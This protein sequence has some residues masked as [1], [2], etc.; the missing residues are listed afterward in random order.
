MVAVVVVD[1]MLGHAVVQGGQRG[2]S[3]QRR[4]SSCGGA[5]GGCMG[6]C[7]AEHHIC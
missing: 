4:Q 1:V 2:S 7:V 5:S 3:L 6:D